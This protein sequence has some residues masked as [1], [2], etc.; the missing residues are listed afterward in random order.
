MAIRTA[1]ATALPNSASILTSRTL[2]ADRRSCRGKLARH[3]ADAFGRWITIQVS[4]S[5]RAFSAGRGVLG[6]ERTSGTTH[7]SCGWIHV[8]ISL[9]TWACRAYCDTSSAHFTGQTA[10]TRGYW[11]RVMVDSAGGTVR[12]RADSTSRI[13]YI[14]VCP[15]GAILTWRC[16]VLVQ[17]STPRQAW[18]TC[19][20]GKVGELTHGTQ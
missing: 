9:A 8:R 15:S 2:C 18:L 5:T 19:M 13:L 11:V 20:G 1:G 3:A 14:C 6:R 4:P 17:I 16:W 10:S 7:T 12:T